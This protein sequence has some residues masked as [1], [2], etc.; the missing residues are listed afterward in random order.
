MAREE[1]RV[2]ASA[3]EHVFEQ[4]EGDDMRIEGDDQALAT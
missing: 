2:H 1:I 3:T 4:R